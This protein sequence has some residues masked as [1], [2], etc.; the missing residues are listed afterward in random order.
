MKER[1]AGDLRNAEQSGKGGINYL[2]HGEMI[3]IARDYARNA[4]AEFLQVAWSRGVAYEHKTDTA[5]E[6]DDSL[7][8][9]TEREDRLLRVSSFSPRRRKG[10]L[11]RSG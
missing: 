5:Q 3:R 4:H 10:N 8:H 2:Q 7:W 1:G 11:R 9:S 6:R